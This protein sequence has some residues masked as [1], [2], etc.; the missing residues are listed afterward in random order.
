MFT[1]LFSQLFLCSSLCQ[2]R[3]SSCVEKG[4]CSISELC[5]SEALKKRIMTITVLVG[6]LGRW[7]EPYLCL[8]LSTWYLT[9]HWCHDLILIC[10]VILDLFILYCKSH[11]LVLLQPLLALWW[12]PAEPSHE[13]INSSTASIPVHQCLCWII[14]TSFQHWFPSSFSRIDILPKWMPGCR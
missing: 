6:S 13:N 14:F 2:A 1:F 12:S 3:K 11:S 8:Y 7:P 4:H 10:D 9:W 5:A